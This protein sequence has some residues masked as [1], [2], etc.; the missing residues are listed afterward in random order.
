MDNKLPTYYI[1]EESDIIVM[2]KII[3]FIKIKREFLKL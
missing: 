1:F 3:I 2:L